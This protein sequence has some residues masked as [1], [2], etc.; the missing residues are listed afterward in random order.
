VEVTKVRG[1]PARRYC[2]VTVNCG[3]EGG[4][5]CSCILLGALSSKFASLASRAVKVS[6]NSSN[7]EV[8]C[9]ILLCSSLLGVLEYLSRF[10]LAQREM[11]EERFPLV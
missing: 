4:I 3:A 6:F 5:N 11:E 7:C 8:C 2:I 9:T 1:E 10:V